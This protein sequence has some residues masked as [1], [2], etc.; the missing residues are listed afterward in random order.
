MAL[1]SVLEHSER[2]HGQTEDK[3]WGGRL[4]V[5]LGSERKMITQGEKE[6]GEC[7]EEKWKENEV[8]TQ[9]VGKTFY[10]YG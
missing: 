3:T 8:Q 6:K 2:T 9:T 10:T 1:I 5:V 7:A 4:W